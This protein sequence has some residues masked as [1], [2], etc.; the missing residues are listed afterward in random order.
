MYARGD[1]G[2]HAG[3]LAGRDQVV[4]IA[5]SCDG[6]MPRMGNRVFQ[7]TAQPLVAVGLVAEGGSKIKSRAWSGGWVAQDTP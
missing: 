6:H 7:P 5:C 3:V 2:G 4:S 1:D